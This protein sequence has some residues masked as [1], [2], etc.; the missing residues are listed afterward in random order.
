VVLRGRSGPA[1]SQATICD[2]RGRPS[3]ALRGANLAFE[4]LHMTQRSHDGLE[5]GVT[6]CLSGLISDLSKSKFPG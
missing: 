4:R 5:K 6:R 2:L 1:N 3:L